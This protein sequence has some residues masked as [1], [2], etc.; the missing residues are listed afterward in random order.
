MQLKLIIVLALLAINCNLGYAINPSKKEIKI[1]NHETNN[2]IQYANV[3]WAY[4]D[5]ISDNKNTIS[6]KEGNIFLNSSKNKSIV[7]SVTCIGFK[8]FYDTIKVAKTNKIYLTEDIFNLEQVT[9]TATRTPVTVKQSPVLIQVVSNKEIERLNAVSP[10]D[11]LEA[12][13]P[14]VEIAYHGYGPSLKV[15]G[16]SANYSLILIDG[17]R[18]AGE[19]DGNIDFNKINLTDIE[20]VEVL[21]GANSTLYGSNAMGSV[22]NFITKKNN[23]KFNLNVDLRYDSKNQKNYSDNELKLVHN[24]NLKFYLKNHDLNNLNTNLNLNFKIKDIYSNTSLNFKNI[25]GYELTTTE[26]TEKY[27]HQRNIQLSDKSAL[28]TK[29]GFSGYQNINVTQKFR[30]DRGKNWTHQIQGNYYQSEEFDFINNGKHKFAKSFSIIEKSKFKI[31]KNQSLN[32]A[33]NYDKYY[34][35]DAFDRSTS[36]QKVYSQNFNNIKLSYSTRIN[37]HK[38][39]IGTENLFEILETDMFDASENIRKRDANNIVAFIQ[40]E[41]KSSDKLSFIGGIRTNYHSN[42]NLHATP[43]ISSKYIL[44]NFNFR[45]SYAR[46]FR[47]PSL[48]ELY[49]NW[50]HLGMFNIYGN[51]NI[52]P[53]TNNHYS[54]STDYIN[55]KKHLNVTFIGSYNHIYN[56]IG[57]Y[58]KGQDYYYDNISEQSLLNI[59]LIVKWKFAKY[60]LFK[61]GYINTNIIESSQEYN[62]S[63]ISPHLFTSQLS[64]NY[65]KRNYD[66]KVNISGKLSS[67]KEYSILAGDTEEFPNEYYQIT[68]PTYTLWNASINQSYQRYSLNIGVKNIFDYISPVINFNTPASPGRRFYIS[69]GYKI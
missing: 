11:I 18:I 21:R 51:Q 6:D 4:V 37:K 44:H 27:Y 28:G 5:E 49:T 59:E 33:V 61:G 68:N 63:P 55:P 58:Q 35:Y 42:Y 1:V 2:P 56:K 50:S 9:V 17:E 30:F 23:S 7:I 36:K 48:K 65:K 62:T 66:L 39:L 29:L 16:L 60:F 24:N 38:I 32:F 67:K 53:E 31:S 3:M 12:E 54:F 20:R 69:L 40:D 19:T 25:D 22:I 10:L 47:S 14:G 57:I 45:L 64:Y 15:Q 52:K 46:G 34:K 26:A 8:P 43:S 41:F 13:I